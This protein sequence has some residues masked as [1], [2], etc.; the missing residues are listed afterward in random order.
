MN[1]TARDRFA[2]L[3]PALARVVLGALAALCLAAA[4]APL[5]SGDGVISGAGQAGAAKARA[6]ITD[7]RDDDLKLYDVVIARMAKGESYYPVVVE[8][9][10][11][12]DYPLRPGFSVRLPTLAWIAALIGPMGLGAASLA[13]L[14]ANMA[15]WWRRLGEELPSIQRLVAMFALLFGCSLLTI[16]YFHVLHELWAGGL[17]ALAFALHRP[18]KGRWLGAFIAA[19]AALAIREHALPFVLLMAAT[20]LWHRR[21]REGAAWVA[22]V[23]TFL[24]ALA[25]H[26]S[27]VAGYTLPGDPAGASWL[28]LRGLSG[29]LSMFILSSNLRL[30]PQEIAKPLVV[31]LLFAWAS[32]K[33]PLATFGTLL[34]AGY[35]LA[36]AIAGRGDNWYWGMTVMPAFFVS[37]VILPGALA[38][39]LHAAFPARAVAH[40]AALGQS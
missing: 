16:R 19:A 6:T 25:V 36:F 13:L 11:R 35:A 17:L 22:L 23:A 12:A 8:E 10:R 5:K 32:W 4:L 7:G 40:G 28:T 37:A 20:A 33:S 30:I 39:L 34:F 38:S 21:W 27:I 1:S 31:L 15:A 9:H 14:A 2:G 18:G 29:W 26:L 24:G 3:S